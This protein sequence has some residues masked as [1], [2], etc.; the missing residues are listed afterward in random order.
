MLH[1]HGLA[2]LT[3]KTITRDAGAAGGPGGP[4]APRGYA[5]DDEEHAVGLRCIAAV[6][7]NEAAEPVAAM[8]LSGP[9]A[10]IPDERI[11]VLGELVRRKADAATAGLGGVL[12]GWRGAGQS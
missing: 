11:P 6:V 8:S 3:V 4:R 10:R 9:M 12:P 5:M 1:R 2:R 7:F